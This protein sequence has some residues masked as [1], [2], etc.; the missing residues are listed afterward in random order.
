[1]H[2]LFLNILFVKVDWTLEIEEKHILFRGQLV[3]LGITRFVDDH[4]ASSASCIQQTR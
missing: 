4:P 1:M 2:V 3:S